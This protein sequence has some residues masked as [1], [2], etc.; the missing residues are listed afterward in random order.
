M[1]LI[2]YS[3]F[4]SQISLFIL[5]S[6]INSVAAEEI[7]DRYDLLSKTQAVSTS[8]IDLVAQQ[9]SITR[10]TGV[11]VNQT[12]KGLEVVLKTAAGG[13]R[14]VP[15]ILLEGNKL[16]IDILDA[17]LAFGIRNGVEKLNPAEGITKITVNKIDENSIRVRILGQTQAPSAEV[18]PSNQNLVLSINPQG[19]TARQT[20]DEEIEVIAT[21][22]GEEDDYYVPEANTATRTDTPLRDVPQSIQVIPQQVIE[23][24]GSN[25]LEDAVRNVSGVSTGDNFG[26]TI[27]RF[28][29]RGFAQ[30]IVLKDGFRQASFGQGLVNLEQLERIEV[31]K[32]PASVL[33]GNLEPG[34]VINL[35]TKKPLREPFSSTNIE[36]GNYGFFQTNFDFS[37]PVNTDKSLL[38]RLNTSFEAED[39]WR[40]YDQNVSRVAI[41]PS[42][43]WQIGKNTNL[44]VDFSYL[45]EER[46][47]DRGLVAF[48]DE[49]ADIPLDRILQDPDAEA[50]NEQLNAS[51]QL[52]HKFSDNWR[53]RQSFRLLSSDTSDFKLD[54]D[55]TDDSG[56]LGRSWAANS[57]L[58][59]NYSLQ[60][61]VVGKFATGKIEHQLLFGVDLDRATRVGRQRR[62]PEEPSFPIN[63]FTLE[64]EPIIRPDLADLTLLS[65]DENTRSDLLGIYLQD[66]ITLLNELKLLVGGRVDVFEQ[67]AIDFTTNTTTQQTG[68]KF[69]PRVGLVYQPSQQISFYTSYSQSFNP[70]E[71][72]ITVDGTFVE[73]STGEQFEVG[74]K[75]EFWDGRLSTNLAAYQINKNNIGTTDPDN[76]DFSIAVGEARSRGIELDVAGEILPGWNVI[77]AYAYTDAEITQDNFYE[78]GNRLSN[79]PE[80]SFS[81]WTSY[82]FQKGF[83][84]GFG[85]GTGVFYVG[86]RQGDFDNSFTL[87]SYTRTDAVLFY[88]QNNWEASLNFQNLFDVDYIKSSENYREA[89]RPGNPFTVIGSVSVKF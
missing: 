40:D 37:G 39:G 10:V 74:V 81:L 49:V 61:N 50:D 88:R 82:E 14:L 72:S 57:D 34:G 41:A 19:T 78:V 6:S 45:N 13:Q 27:D 5:L 71:F 31:L 44:L 62:L 68:E 21:G 89:I 30:E 42:L 66:Q 43:S 33:Y 12:N 24:Q 65:R 73:P 23:D 47:F 28:N 18:I 53:L 64:A 58:I 69:S 51:Y 9:N 22:E 38:Y 3:F 70:D 46:P 4:L 32:G 67:K 77:A 20:P 75:G 29:I 15:L 2:Q 48:G 60:A 36:L 80:N 59:E 76:P 8:A 79:V 85:V 7:G 87:P 11:E 52:E 17:T 63:I 83:L 26:N 35:V 54:A 56:I 86:D 16:A 1:K 55:S 25:R 84:E